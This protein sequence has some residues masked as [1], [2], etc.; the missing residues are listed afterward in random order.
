MSEMERLLAIMGR[1]R[2]PQGG[3]P[4]DLAQT[5]ET[6]VPF[7]LEE[8]YEVADAIE[9]GDLDGLQEELGDLLFQVVFHAHLA[10]EAGHFDFHR[11]AAAICDKLV[12]RHP[13]VFGDAPVEDAGS[14][15]RAWEAH[16]ARERNDRAAAEGRRPGLLDNIPAPLPA[17][18]RAMKL[19]RRTA[20]A[21][22]DWED[23]GEIFAKFDEELAELRAALDSG[24]APEEVDEEVG[25]LLFTL[26]NLARHLDCDPEGA[27]RRTNRK[28]ERRFRYIEERLAE[29]GRRP[30]DATLNEM[31]TL[32][33]EAKLDQRR[34]G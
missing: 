19:Q 18:P 29:E 24:A 7:T 22:F 5:F 16:K 3:C 11:V 15:T 27:L 12:R 25:D 8:A 32:W 21:G 31:D 26:V 28:F 13:H 4:W 10:R 30:E 6:I 34:D 20:R 1:L 14:Q 33:H 23:R 17:L 2:D 9:R